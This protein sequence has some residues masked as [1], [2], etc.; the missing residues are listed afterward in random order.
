[1]TKFDRE[2]EQA[3][4][5]AAARNAQELLSSLQK[6]YDGADPHHNY[7]HESAAL[8]TLLFSAAVMAALEAFPDAGDDEDIQHTADCFNL[9]LETYGKFTKSEVM[10]S[11]DEL[12]ELN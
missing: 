1:M 8:Y 6:F 2:R 4:H 12:E 10:P 9:L 11:V 7:D 5:N 3:A